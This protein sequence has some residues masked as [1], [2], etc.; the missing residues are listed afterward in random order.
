MIGLVL[1][2]RGARTDRL[3]ASLI[4][5]GG[6]TVVSALVFSL[7]EGI[8]HQY[9]T[10]ALAPGIAALVG[11]GGAL[12][13]QRRES[14]AARAGMAA[15][16]V[17]TAVWAW[18]LL[19]RTPEFAPWVRW[20]VVA[21]G[22][23][24]AALFLLPVRGRVVAAGALA[25][26]V[27][28]GLLGPAAY[29][30]DTVSATHAGSIPL[31]GPSTGGGFGGPGGRAG[32][33][34]GD[35][36]TRDRGSD[37]AGAGGTARSGTTGG[38]TTGGASSG[39]SGGAAAAAPRA[40]G[41]RRGRQAVPAVRRPGRGQGGRPGTGEPAAGGRHEVVRG[42]G[43]DDAGGPARARQR[44]RRHGDRR[45]LRRRPGA[46]AG[47]V[48]GLRR[49][50]DRCTTSSRAVGSAGLGGPTWRTTPR[51]ARRVDDQRVGGAALHRDDRRRAHRL[52]P[53]E[54]EGLTEAGD[55][56]LL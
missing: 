13:W 45:L 21:L 34:R 10:V 12:L 54:A 39:S 4:V 18:V 8:F 27:V 5:W 48:P 2:R 35:R 23:V 33:A 53:H 32:A 43:R 14:R 51:R 7:M 28:S 1:T 26:A 17:L 30:V 15:L 31:A 29:A 20:V 9:Y 44:H 25:A 56:T 3:R 16:V 50:R 11:I 6:W 41:T 37:A 24:G 38:A 49:G 22:V 42:H 55:V 47:P 19:S 46:V 52:R 36:F 40:P